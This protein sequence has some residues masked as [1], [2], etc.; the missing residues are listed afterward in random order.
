MAT[1][2]NYDTIMPDLP[3][4]LGKYFLDMAILMFRTSCS[5]LQKH[6]HPKIL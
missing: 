2:Q 4:T 1:V 6:A 3:I 5:I